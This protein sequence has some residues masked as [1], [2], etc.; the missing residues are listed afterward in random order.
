MPSLITPR[1]II[2]SPRTIRQYATPHATQQIIIIKLHA[3][4]KR[5]QINDDKPFHTVK[6]TYHRRMVRVDILERLVRRGMVRGREEGTI[7][8]QHHI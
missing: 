2:I 1:A 5:V 6:S 8:I 7:V 3:F 4:K